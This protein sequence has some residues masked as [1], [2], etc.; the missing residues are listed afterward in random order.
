VLGV[1]FIFGSGQPGVQALVLTFLCFA[2]GT[3][4]TMS[5]PMRSPEVT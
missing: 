2:L 1:V 3:A 5:V 4:H